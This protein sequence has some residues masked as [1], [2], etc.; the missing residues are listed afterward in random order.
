MDLFYCHYLSH[1]GN[2]VFS[3]LLQL[4]IFPDIYSIW[5]IAPPFTS[6]SPINYI[7]FHLK[8]ANAI[9]GTR[10]A[11]YSHM[12]S[13][14]QT[15]LFDDSAS[16]WNIL[17]CCLQNQQIQIP[18]AV[19][20][21]MISTAWRRAHNRWNFFYLLHGSTQLC[22]IWTLRDLN[23]S[24]WIYLQSAGWSVSHLAWVFKL[25]NRDQHMAQ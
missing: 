3:L 11:V 21:S 22:F 25:A 10:E 8:S 20:V 7:M 5:I 23:F 15:L 6:K 4:V 12:S 24:Q 9:N 13:N 18:P 16:N 19:R 17:V 14:M 1:R 2:T